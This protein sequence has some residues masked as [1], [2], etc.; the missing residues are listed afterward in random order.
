MQRLLHFN[1][2]FHILT[3]TNSIAIDGVLSAGDVSFKDKGSIKIR[4]LRDNASTFVLEASQGLATIQ[5]RADEVICVDKGEI[6][7]QGHQDEVAAA[8]RTSLKVASSA[9]TM[10][11]L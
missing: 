8:Y 6:K 3:A 11:N 2:M 1:P 5:E 7:M 9:A 4:S 10:G